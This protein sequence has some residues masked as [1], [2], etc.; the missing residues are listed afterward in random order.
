MLPFAA[1]ILAADTTQNNN[2]NNNNA[3]TPQTFKFPSSYG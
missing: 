2:N 1:L 3:N